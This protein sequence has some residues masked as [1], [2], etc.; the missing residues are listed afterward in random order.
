MDVDFNWVSDWTSHVLILAVC[1]K[2][3]IMKTP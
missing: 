1:V 2:C 3:Y